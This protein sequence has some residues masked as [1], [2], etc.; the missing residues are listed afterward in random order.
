[1]GGANCEV[2]KIVR[3]GQRQTNYGGTSLIR[4]HL[5]E[6]EKIVRCPDFG[7]CNVHKQGV[8]TAKCVLF[9]GVLISVCPD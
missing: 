3:G 1:M 2:A 7:G 5:E 6:K 9:Q 4:T 8:G